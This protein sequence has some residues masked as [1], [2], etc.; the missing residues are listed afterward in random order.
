MKKITIEL[1]EEQIMFIQENL[2]IMLTD[3]IND[4]NDKDFSTMGLSKSNCIDL[5]NKL[6]DL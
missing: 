4:L 6:R 1:S 3:L 5:Q 2:D